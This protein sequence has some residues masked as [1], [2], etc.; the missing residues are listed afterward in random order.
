MTDTT[1]KT[2]SNYQNVWTA[3]KSISNARFLAV[4][5]MLSALAFVLMYLDF[6]IPFLIPGFVKMDFSEL[7]A[8]IAAFSMGPVSGVMVCL[9][10]NL[11]HL[12]VTSTGG[13]GELCNF[14]LGAA[15]VLPAGLIYQHKKTKKTAIG[16]ALVGAISMAIIS[17]PVN[18]FITYPVYEQL[19]FGG[20]VE[21]IIGMY[22]EIL[23]AVQNL[24]QC[25]LIFN[26]PF[27]FVK[28]LLSV[29]ITLFIYKPL[30]PVLH[31]RQ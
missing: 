23:P 7:P 18:L 29:I 14:L 27:T 22:R 28:G 5:A 31:G 1:N 19:Y 9:I 11:L 13:I 17:F 15:F 8:L 16:G 21:P 30:S 4:T 6:A 12:F 20:S 25:L 10:K 2:N 24:W 26:A 3:H